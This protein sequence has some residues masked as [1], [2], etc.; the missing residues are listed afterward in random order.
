MRRLFWV[1]VGAAGTVTALRKA[2][3]VTD[4]HVPA[5]ARSALGAAA[6]VTGAVRRA[7][8]EFRTATAQRESELRADLLAGADL[9]RSR[10]TVD[11][12]RAQRAASSGAD[13][14]SG[15]SASDPRAGD[16]GGRARPGGGSH[17]AEDPEDGPE[18][19][20]FY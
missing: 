10:T 14:A 2:R 20:S 18:G 9:A 3:E 6:G 11:A 5:G 15:A 19:Y 17:R 12:W 16:R 13:G 1:A 4:R 7:R 8:E